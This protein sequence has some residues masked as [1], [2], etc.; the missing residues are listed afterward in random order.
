MFGV[1]RRL[2]PSHG[3]TAAPEQFEGLRVDQRADVYSAGVIL[4]ELLS[5]ADS[6]GRYESAQSLFASRRAGGDARV[7]KKLNVSRPL[8]VALT[9]SLEVDVSRRWANAAEFRLALS[10]TPEG[11]ADTTGHDPQR[12]RTEWEEQS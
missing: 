10:K 3:A 9:K 2:E 7:V 1:G 6:A 12:A 4:L 11:A 5:D 8:R